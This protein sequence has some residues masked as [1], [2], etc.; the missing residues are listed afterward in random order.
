MAVGW[1]P[2]VMAIAQS[3]LP[4]HANLE[5]ATCLEL[6]ATVPALTAPAPT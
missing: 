2:E 3:C 5:R 6:Y 1:W 4:H